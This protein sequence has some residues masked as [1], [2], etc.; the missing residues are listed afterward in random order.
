MWW[1]EWWKYHEI[2]F[3]TYKQIFRLS[4]YKKFYVWWD[5]QMF[6]ILIVFLGNV[7]TFR[8]YIE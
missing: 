6:F 1:S 2:I 7:S 4:K 5:L 3:L 8:L